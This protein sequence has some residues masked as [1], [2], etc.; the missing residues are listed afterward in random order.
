VPQ[1]FYVDTERKL[2]LDLH[3]P[4]IDKFVI[5]KDGKEYRRIEDVFDV[6]FDSGSMP[7]A[8]KHYPFSNEKFDPVGGFLKSTKGFP[9]DFIAEGLD[10]T[11]GWFYVL[12][13]LG[14]A[15]FDK[16]PFKNVAVNGLVLAEDGKKMSK[17]L[18]N[19]PEMDYTINKYGADALRLFLMNSPAVRGE[20]V[21][22]S[23]KGVNEIL[24]KVMGRLRNILTFWQMYQKGEKAKPRKKNILDAWIIARLD[25]T[26]KEVTEALNKY[27]IDKGA[28]PIIDFVDDFSNWYVRRSRDRFKSDDKQD[29]EHSLATTRFVLREI[30]K[31]AAPYV[32]F[33]AE[34]VYR[35][36]SKDK[37]ESVHLESWPKKR[38]FDKKVIEKMSIVRDV[39]SLGLMERQKLDIKVKQPLKSLTIKEKLSKEYL[40]LIK[41]E[42]N[43][44][45][46]LF[47]ESL[48]LDTEITEELKLEGDFREFLRFV[49]SLRKD[50]NLKP[51]EKISIFV[52]TDEYGKKIINTFTSMLE[53]VAGVSSVK[54][55]T[56]EGFDLSLETTNFKVMIKK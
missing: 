55:G 28:K 8:Q 42:V 34:E 19:Y 26:T 33:V 25:E 10:Q 22:F 46:V 40:E 21:A 5:K 52:E 1:I 30:S 36:V 41:D 47:G 39:V 48:A 51:E 17:R 38:G 9:A 54:F 13:V 53:K 45:D 7:Y 49:Q 43:V 11:R 20:D 2:E 50:A 29:R 6:W 12:M 37:E 23:E 16:S 44:K 56:K 15:L 27:E 35:A 31:L 4:H 24:N 3:R 14:T 32:P 18:K